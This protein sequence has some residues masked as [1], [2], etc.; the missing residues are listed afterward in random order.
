MNNE[1]MQDSESLDQKRSSI[2]SELKEIERL[3]NSAASE[4]K[5]LASSRLEELENS[6]EKSEESNLLEDSEIADYYEKIKEQMREEQ[7]NI[8]ASNP[9]SSPDASAPEAAA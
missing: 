7:E 1:K 3:L 9:Y 2:M 4:E 5:E 8:M 6:L